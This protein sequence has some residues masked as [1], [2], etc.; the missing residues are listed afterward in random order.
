VGKSGQQSASGKKLL[1]SELK[2]DRY[3]CESDY[4]LAEVLQSVNQTRSP[5]L[6]AGP[7]MIW[8]RRLN[9]GYNGLG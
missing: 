2:A 8:P 7:L 4:R 9:A 3:S 5:G 1:F 6:N